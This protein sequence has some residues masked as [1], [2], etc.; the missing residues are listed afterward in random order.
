MRKYHHQVPAPKLWT[1]KDIAAR[2]GVTT[3]SVRVWSHRD[4]FP[5]PAGIIGHIR[6]WVAADVEA[7]IAEHRPGQDSA[8]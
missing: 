8:T 4:D 7:W 6:V 1:S 2:A 5:E 3:E